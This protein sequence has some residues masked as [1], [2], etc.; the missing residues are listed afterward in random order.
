MRNNNSNLAFD[1]TR[2][3][4]PALGAVKTNITPVS[5]NSVGL[6]GDADLIL[7]GLLEGLPLPA[8]CSTGQI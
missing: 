6:S 3:R 8:Y 1:Q 4:W 2:S 5:H 7:I